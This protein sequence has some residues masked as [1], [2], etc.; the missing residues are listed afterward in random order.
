MRK[1][2]PPAYFKNI[3]AHRLFGTISIKTASEILKITNPTYL[4][5]ERII[6]PTITREDRIPLSELEKKIKDFGKN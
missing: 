1:F 3:V 6:G 4:K 2:N 5:Y